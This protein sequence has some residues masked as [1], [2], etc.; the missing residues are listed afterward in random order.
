MQTKFTWPPKEF[1]DYVESQIQEYIKQ[2]IKGITPSSD[3]PQ[4]ALRRLIQ[5]NV[6]DSLKNRMPKLIEA[7]GEP[8]VLNYLK[9]VCDCYDE[10][11]Y[12]TPIKI[13]EYWEWLRKIT[14]LSMELHWVLREGPSETLLRVD[15][16]NHLDAT[17]LAVLEGYG[18]DIAIEEFKHEGTPLMRVTKTTPLHFFFEAVARLAALET[19]NAPVFSWQE[20]F[21][22]DGPKHIGDSGKKGIEAITARALKRLTIDSFDAPHSEIVADLLNRHFNT[23]RFDSD[24]LNHIRL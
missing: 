20:S 15:W 14:K 6:V 9:K 13:E 10:I 21:H 7:H 11:G 17:L 12:L 1:K 8:K 23:T 16:I 3:S 4:N 24:A 2:Q 19:K 22:I 5:P 18:D